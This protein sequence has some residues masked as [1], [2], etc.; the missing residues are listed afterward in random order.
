MVLLSLLQAAQFG[1]LKESHVIPRSHGIPYKGDRAISMGA[2][3]RH[4]SNAQKLQKL[5]T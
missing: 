5:S 2:C 3:I 1:T 4:H